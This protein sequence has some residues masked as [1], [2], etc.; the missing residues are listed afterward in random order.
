MHEPPAQATPHTFSPFYAQITRLRYIK[1]WGLM[2]CSIEED[3]AQHSWEVA[4]LAHALATIAKDLFGKEIDPCRVATMALFHDATES[5]TG[6]LPTPVKHSKLL[7]DATA[8]LESHVCAE[9]LKLLPPE[10]RPSISTFVDHQHFSPSESQTIKTAD[11]L[12]AWLK[13]RNELRNGNQEFA[14]AEKQILAKLEQNMT[15]ELQYFLR[16]FAQAFDLSL[17]QLM[18]P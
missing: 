3:V 1:R 6:D 18:Q 9:M 16:T 12:S 14:H 10:L 4:I 17:D 2:R 7:R 8:N 15:P 13:C 5:I 11:W